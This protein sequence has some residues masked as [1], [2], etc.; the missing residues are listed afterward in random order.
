MT[1]GDVW[2]VTCKKPDCEWQITVSDDEADSPRKYAKGRELL[3]RSQKTHPTEMERIG[4]ENAES[5]IGGGMNLP[6]VIES[7]EELQE[8]LEDFFEANGWTAIREVS[9][10]SSNYRA[11]LVVKNEEYGWFGIETKYMHL[12][13][14]GK[15][16]KAHHQITEQYRGQ[17]YLGEK[18]D[19]WVI[20]PYFRG[21]NSPDYPMKERQEKIRAKF[22]REFFSRHGIGYID[23]DRYQL[24]LDFAYSQPWA[25]VPVG[26]D[27]LEK[28]QENVDILK[29]DESVGNKIEK[30]SY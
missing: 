14:G 19:R 8:W 26:G 3:H 24:L 9:P 13:G 18:I 1:R 27:Y 12:D 21:M 7:E 6:G 20:C 17:R 2:K 11:D 30:Y 4:V 10:H 29:I 15:I 25:K 5:L 23:L 16:A 28:Y 22:T